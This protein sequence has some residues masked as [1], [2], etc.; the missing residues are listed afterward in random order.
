MASSFSGLSVE[1]AGLWPGCFEVRQAKLLDLP[2]LQPKGLHDDGG[3][4]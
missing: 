4:R 3:M 1:V 2:T